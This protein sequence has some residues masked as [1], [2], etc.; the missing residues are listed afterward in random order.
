MVKILL[1]HGPDLTAYTTVVDS[2]A[3]DACVRAGAGQA[4][5]LPVGCTLDTRFHQPVTLEGIVRHVGQAPVRL[6][7]PC[8]T[9]WK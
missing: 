4:V 7:R 8:S 5:R 1:D 3:V 9:A 2:P 6:T